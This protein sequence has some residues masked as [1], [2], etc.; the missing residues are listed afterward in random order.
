MLHDV[1][2]IQKVLRIEKL[3]HNI[4]LKKD[5]CI[6]LY[7]DVKVTH[8]PSQS[9]QLQIFKNKLSIWVYSIWFTDDKAKV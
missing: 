5:G 2:Y 8:N 7:V 3:G 9:V 4:L 1:F 6:F